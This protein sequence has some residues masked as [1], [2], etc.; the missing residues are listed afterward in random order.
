M[1]LPRYALDHRTVVL[2]FL[3]VAM[4]TGLINFLNMP[5]REDPKVNFRDALLITSWPGASAERVD[6]LITDP[7]ENAIVQIAEIDI[8]RSKSMTGVSVIQLTADDKVQDTDQVWDDVRAK[9]ETAQSVLPPGSDPPFLNSDYGDV[10]EIVF[11][12]HQVPVQGAAAIEQR[13]TPRQLERFAERIEDELRLINAVGKIEFWGL[14]QERVYIEVDSADW[15]KLEI[16]PQDLRAVFSARNIVEPGGELDTDRARYAINTSGEFSS[17]AQIQ[18]LIIDRRLGKLPVRLGDLP[19]RVDR[20]YEEPVTSLT[21]VSLPGLAHQPA[22]VIGISMKSG[23]NVVELSHAVDD[24]L[25][26]LAATELPPDLMLTRVN[27]LPRQ[28]ETRISDF[29]FNLVQGVLIVLGVALLAMGWRPA[30]IMATAIPISMVTAFAVVRFFGVELEQFSIA[31]LVIALG[32]VVDSAIVVSD[33]AFRLMRDGVPKRDAIVRGAHDLAVPLLASTLTTVLAFLPIL[34]IAGNA[35]EY[36]ASLP[37]VVSLTLAAS[38][39]VA[40][41]V[42]PIMCWWL[43]HPPKELQLEASAIASPSRYESLMH[44]CLRHKG[45]VLGAT[46]LLFAGSLT[47]LPLIGSQFFPAGARDQFF[48][49]I[50]LPEGSPIAATSRVAKQ[51]ES[52][53]LKYSRLKYDNENPERLASI[54]TYVGVGGPRIMLT[55]A[56]E[57]NYPY[58]A[59]LLVNTTDPAYT[60]GFAQDVRTE[61]SHIYDARITVEQFMLGPPIRDPVAFRL[62]GPNT[63]FLLEQA[64]KIV[65]LY[66]QTEGVEH[67]YSDWGSTAYAV[68]LKVDPYAASLAGVTHSDI[69]SATRTLLSGSILTTYR[70][71]DH[72]VPV[73]LRTLREG[74]RKLNDLSGIFVDGAFG[75]VPLNSLAEIETTWQPAVIA[76][77]NKLHTITVGARVVPGVLANSVASTIKLELTQMLE[78]LPPGYFIEQGG[79]Q[80]QTQKTRGEFVQAVLIA[81]ILMALVLVIQYNSILKPLV[82]LMTVPLA[83]IGVLTGLWVTGWAMGFMAML[84]VLALGGIVINNAIVLIDFIEDALAKGVPLRQAVVSAGRLRIRPILLT[85]LTTIGGLL[86]LSLFGGALW[87]PMTNGMI[88][89]LVVSTALTLLVVPVMYVLFAEKLNMRTPSPEAVAVK[90]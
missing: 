71:G 21:R 55:Q 65:D 56:P 38:Y 63:D 85:T 76:R 10:Y 24:T 77:R 47:L 90:G 69:S 32:M 9:V 22:L 78:N 88:F 36:V 80:E 66:K 19:I 84:G 81:I 13:Y 41:L 4:V 82:V 7:L 29:Q 16:T 34:T 67:P 50:W 23:N 28:V 37:I 40:M 68:D 86:P 48:I 62:S 30:L 11:A 57:N 33:N 79:E 44:W 20:R 83:L 27:D 2:V 18:D 12:L 51:V 75:K 46:A 6:E 26:R 1:N 49:K 87:A 14:Q 60:P 73:V 5:R 8:I 61:V 58:Y 42:T 17:V 70:E 64:P 52:I 3:T 25:T 35:G 15:A 39:L 54:V 43:L 53:V 31:S 74:R 59:M 45:L 89:G 72:Q